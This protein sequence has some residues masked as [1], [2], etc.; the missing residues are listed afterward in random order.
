MIINKN[1]KDSLFRSMFNDNSNL[2]ELVNA[3]LGTDFKDESIIEINTLLD[4]IFAA[5]K[6]DISLTIMGIMLMLIE[7]QSTINE[8]MA[9]RML[10]YV[11]RI[12]EKKTGKR[13]YQDSLIKIPRPKFIVLYNGT[14]PFPKE[15]IIRLSDAFISDPFEKID[16]SGLIDLDLIVRV[17]NINKGVNPELE[18][19][20]ETL[21]AYV[22]FIAKVREYEKQYPRA[23][24]G[25]LAVKYC[26]KN[27]IKADYFK[28]N[29]S[30]VIRMSLAE[31][32]VKDHIEVIR[33]EYMEKGIEKG[34]KKG[35]NYVLELMAQGL[36]YE[37]IKK[38]IEKTPQKKHK[39]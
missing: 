1:Y 34:L 9:V 12:Y 3:I 32:N 6:N 35:Q 26:I 8:N 25:K 16:N 30:E 31:Y 18:R 10:S 23:E 11:A 24:A 37:E 29:S 5:L 19:K 20:S 36:S 39:S 22:T 17:I 14:D 15:K 33:E 7:H 4:V 2:L 21:Y 13:I 28:Q 38:K 27:D